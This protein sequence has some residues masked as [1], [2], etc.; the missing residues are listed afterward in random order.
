VLGKAS[1]GDGKKSLSQSL[2]GSGL[3]PAE[4]DCFGCQLP[5]RDRYLMAISDG[6]CYWHESCLKC[7][8]CRVGLTHS[9]YVRDAKFYCKTDYNK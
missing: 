8:V 6:D 5:I 1:S 9:C 4:V 3:R 7:T 2:N